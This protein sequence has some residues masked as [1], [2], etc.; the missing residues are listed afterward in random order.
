MDAG[1]WVLQFLNALQ[2]SML[3]FLLSIGPVFFML[4]SQASLM[5]RWFAASPEAGDPYVLYGASNLG[6][7]GGLIA[8]PLIFEPTMPLATQSHLWSADLGP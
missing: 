6:S 2:Y 1:F 4:S 3:L 8:Y 7:F 5:Q